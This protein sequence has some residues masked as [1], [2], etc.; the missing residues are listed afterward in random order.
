MAIGD[1]AETRN[2]EGRDAS[3]DRSIPSVDPIEITAA[4]A[5]DSDGSSPLGYLANGQPR[6]RRRRTQE[7]I[8]ADKA[9]GIERPRPIV[10]TQKNP[11]LSVNS[12]QFSLTGIHALLAAGFHAPEME[13]TEAEAKTFSENII[14]VARHYDLQQTQ[15]ATDIGNLVVS[16]GIIYGGRAIRI[17][18]RLNAENT[19]RRQQAAAHNM[20]LSAVA[21]VTNPQ[22]PNQGNGAKPPPVATRAKV[23][24]DLALLNEHE[25]YVA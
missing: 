10:A 3:L 23:D 12:I 14:A 21:T 15:K 11:S 25:A 17:S 1:N 6:Q 4:A 22:P 2:D 7:Q 24:A 16:L 13:L 5:S 19:R 9:A 18:S 8:A 20:G